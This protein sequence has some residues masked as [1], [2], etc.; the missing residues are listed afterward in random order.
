MT[1]TPEHL[2]GVSARA[3]STNHIVRF[4]L[5][6]S[7]ALVIVAFALVLAYWA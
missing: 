7:L 6:I 2:D 1:D 5:G 4:V 3:G